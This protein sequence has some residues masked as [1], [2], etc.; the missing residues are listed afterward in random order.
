MC[1]WRRRGSYIVRVTSPLDDGA[2][3]KLCISRYGRSKLEASA[4]TAEAAIRRLCC[5]SA[6]V[7]AVDALRAAAEDPAPFDAREF[8]NHMRAKYKLIHQDVTS[9]YDDKEVPEGTVLRTFDP[10]TGLHDSLPGMREE[11]GIAERKMA[12]AGSADELPPHPDAGAQLASGGWACSV[13]TVVNEA[14]NAVCS[15]CDQGKR[16]HEDCSS[17]AAT[18]TAATAAAGA[19]ATAAAAAGQPRERQLRGLRLQ[20]QQQVEHYFS[21]QNLRTDRHLLLLMR[22]DPSAQ[23]TVKVDE[24][25]SFRRIRRAM[26]SVESAD[27]QKERLVAAI[28]GSSVLRVNTGGSRV[29]RCSPVRQASREAP[30]GP[31]TV[32]RGTAE[33]LF[34]ALAGARRLAAPSSCRQKAL[35]VQS[36]GSVAV[37]QPNQRQ[38]G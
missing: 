32:E 6:V 31:N 3:D 38:R 28:R 26:A 33:F 22:A 16:P 8:L 2:T 25:L 7:R 30:F 14:G 29:G 12:A 37:S 35:H 17:Q 23:M 4:H 18:A 1:L 20:L 15:A 19:A 34:G 27:D 5:L 11:L 36:H 13:C 10:Q 24:I 9:V 21:N